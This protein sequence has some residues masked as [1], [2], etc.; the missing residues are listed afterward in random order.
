MT[1]TYRQCGFIQTPEGGN[2]DMVEVSTKPVT[3][4][5]E[6][7]LPSTSTLEGKVIN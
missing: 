3:L 5:I 4:H 1:L 6:L 7:H 2:E